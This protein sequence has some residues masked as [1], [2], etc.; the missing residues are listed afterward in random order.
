MSL[1]LEFEPHSWYMDFA[2]RDNRSSGHDQSHLE[3]PLEATEGYRWSAYTA[4]GMT[5]YIVERHADT[6]RELREL[7]KQYTAAEKAR[8]ERLYNNGK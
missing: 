4:N 7:I 6:L 8:I 2:I 1:H 3:R 5:G